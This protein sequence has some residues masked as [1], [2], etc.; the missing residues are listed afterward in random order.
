MAEAVVNAR[1]GDEWEAYS[2]GTAPSGYVHPKAIQALAEIGIEHEGRSKNAREYLDTPLDLVITVCDDADQN[3]P[4]WLGEGK[5]VHIGYPD[6]AEATGTEEEIMAVF[7][8]V[9]DDISRQIP[10]FLESWQS[11]E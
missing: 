10:E 5:R 8:A 6:P 1:L 3:C 11:D 4:Y 2:A 7:R 9:R